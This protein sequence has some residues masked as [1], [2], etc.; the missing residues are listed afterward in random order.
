MERKIL[1]A[2]QIMI[3]EEMEQ[4]EEEN[5]K[6]KVR[7]SKKVTCKVC[8]TTETWTCRETFPNGLKKWRD[9]DD[10]ICNGKICGKC[11]RDRSKGTMQKMRT[12]RYKKVDFDE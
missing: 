3:E 12:R 2:A 6:P 5:E 4:I 10:L 8:G 9:E 1:E 11:N 7:D